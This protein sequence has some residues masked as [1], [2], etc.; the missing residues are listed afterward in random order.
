M[1]TIHD[2]RDIG[3]PVRGFIDDRD[4]AKAHEMAQALGI[5]EERRIILSD[6]HM[7]AGDVLNPPVKLGR[8]ENTPSTAAHKIRNVK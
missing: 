7:R 4:P 3:C 1:Y 8:N 5:P 6:P 2:S